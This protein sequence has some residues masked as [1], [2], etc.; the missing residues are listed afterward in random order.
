[1]G[2]DGE[3]VNKRAHKSKK[4]NYFWKNNW[5]KATQIARIVYDEIV[6]DNMKK[7]KL[8]K[9]KKELEQIHSSLLEEKRRYST[10]NK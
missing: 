1:M 3:R 6:L 9:L 7:N 2:N 4:A 8:K 5:N 10:K